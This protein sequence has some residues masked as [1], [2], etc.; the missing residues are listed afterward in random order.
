MDLK[1]LRYFLKAA[2]TGS[3]LAAARHFAVPASSVSRFIAAL[4]KELGQQLFYR[5][6]RAIRLTDDG[7]R[8][9]V[10]A[11]EALE[12]LDSAVA[13]LVQRDERIHGS[14]S[15]NAP[16]ALGRLH[17]AGILNKLQAQYPELKVELTLTDTY[18][19]PVREGADITVRVGPLIDSGLIGKVLAPQRYILA[20]SPTYLKMNGALKKPADLL[21]H[22]C[23][24]YRG[25]RGA[26]RWY[27]RRTPDQEFKQLEVGGLLIS[28][29]SEALVAAALAARGI[30]LLPTWMFNPE[31]FAKN[32]LVVL[33][34]EWEASATVQVSYIQILSPENRLRSR[35]VR[36]VSAFFAREIGTPPYWDEWQR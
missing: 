3:F 13:E 35:K 31:S 16:E 11:S 18:I 1:G 5:S 29:N 30:V 17:V 28:N 27:F 10:Q 7:A 36:E 20:A 33:L 26:Q 4:E 19:D 2:E 12:L 9:Q 21:K 23:L 15:V 14:V 6:T 8:F 25:V 34:R 22:N 32:E 24:L